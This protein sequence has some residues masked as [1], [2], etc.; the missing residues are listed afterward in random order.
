M[1]NQKNKVNK[2]K[3]KAAFKSTYIEMKVLFLFK[4]S[5]NKQSYY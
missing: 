4:Q 3:S 1:F 5:A 2:H